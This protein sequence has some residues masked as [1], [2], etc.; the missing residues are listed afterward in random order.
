MKTNALENPN[1]TVDFFKG[2][3]SGPHL[4]FLILSIIFNQKN[5]TTF[6]GKKLIQS[7]IG[8][9]LNV[10]GKVKVCSLVL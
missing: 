3:I 7:C 1:F 2:Y 6:K 8:G 10:G 5:S 9:S 4:F